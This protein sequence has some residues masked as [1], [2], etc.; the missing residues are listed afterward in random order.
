MIIRLIIGGTTVCTTLY[1]RTM[2][3]C[4]KEYF[5]KKK[6]LTVT[7]FLHFPSRMSSSYIVKMSMFCYQ[8]YFHNSTGFVCLKSQ[9][10]KNWNL[11]YH[12]TS[13][14]NVVQHKKIRSVVH[15]L[16]VRVYIGVLTYEAVT[17]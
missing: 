2:C 9:T 3:G 6:V 8:K 1:K 17:P 15:V 14:K 5:L 4:L 11:E 10:L 16:V 13:L 12:N 7:K